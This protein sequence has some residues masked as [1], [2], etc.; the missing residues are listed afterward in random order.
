MPEHFP[1]LAPGEAVPVTTSRAEDPLLPTLRAALRL[2]PYVNEVGHPH[3]D[4]SFAGP[5]VR[6]GGKYHL[7]LHPDLTP[8]RPPLYLASLPKSPVH[9]ALRSKTQLVH[10][11]QERDYNAVWT[12]ELA[13]PEWRVEAEGGVAEPGLRVLVRHAATGSLLSSDARFLVRNDFAVER[14]VG[15]A[16]VTD[17]STGVEVAQ[18]HW[19]FAATDPRMGTPAV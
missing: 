19:I 7:S 8:G 16:V 9:H 12:L 5:E 3:H 4:V 14:E 13:D 10:L 17:P 18:N 15:C 2:T 11:A 6:F 1:T